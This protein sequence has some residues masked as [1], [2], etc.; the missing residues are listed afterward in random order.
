MAGTYGVPR[1]QG[2]VNVVPGTLSTNIYSSGLANGNKHARQTPTTLYPSNPLFTS[3]RILLIEILHEG[4][5]LLLIS[6][7]K[8]FG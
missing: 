1:N 7:G 2:L 5:T 6:K 8:T 3:S 4:S